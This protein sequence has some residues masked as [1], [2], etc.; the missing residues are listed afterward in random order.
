LSKKEKALEK[1]RQNPKHV[2]FEE[3]E[4]ILLRLGFQ[5]RQDNTSHAM[6]TLG[7]HIVNVP[8]RKPFVKPKYINLVLKALEEIQE[9]INSK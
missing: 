9:E 3:L 5:K 8:K 1:L 7:N 6:F 2:R 4:T